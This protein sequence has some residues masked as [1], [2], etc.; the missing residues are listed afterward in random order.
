MGRVLT[1]EDCGIAKVRNCGIETRVHTE[2]TEAAQRTGSR[3]AASEWRPANCEG[4]LDQSCARHFGLH[5]DA[6]LDAEG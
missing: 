2:D 6:L 4:L 3:R 5:G 1:G